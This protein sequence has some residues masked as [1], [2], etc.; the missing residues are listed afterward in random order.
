M[1][2][3]DIFR[4]PLRLGTVAVAGDSMAPTYMPGDWLLVKWGGRFKLGNTVVIEQEERP[5]VFLIKRFIREED[6]KYWVEGDSESST[7][8]RKWGAIP[9]EEIVGRVLFRIR[10]NT[11][12]H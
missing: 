12:N 6:G 5:G 2:R 8:S 9:K 1:S 10:R 3:S 7:D 4:N 11:E